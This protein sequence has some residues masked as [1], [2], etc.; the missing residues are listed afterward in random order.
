MNNELV[1]CPICWATLNWLPVKLTMEKAKEM[2]DNWFSTVTVDKDWITLEFNAVFWEI[3]NKCSEWMKSWVNLLCDW[4]DS[5]Y[6][7]D[8]EKVK[9]YI[10][11]AKQWDNY[12]IK[13]CPKCSLDKAFHFT[14]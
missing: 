6:T 13:S 10:V 2:K 11:W 1:I 9:E 14:D 7:I 3:C 8:T 5:L 12:A 4:C